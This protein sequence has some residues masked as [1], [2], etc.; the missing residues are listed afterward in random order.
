MAGSISPT[1]RAVARA[2]VSEVHVFVRQGRVSAAVAPCSYGRRHTRSTL[3]QPQP[4]G[5][6]WMW[7]NHGRRADRA[8]TSP[9]TFIYLF[10]AGGLKSFCGANLHN[11]ELCDRAPWYGY[12][13]LANTMAAQSDSLLKY[14]TR[15]LIEPHWVWP[16]RH[17]TLYWITR[18]LNPNQIISIS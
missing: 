15:L 1:C 2:S 6:S 7:H 4:N 3:A 9:N 13:E 18:Q 10:S 17:I 5:S 11:G 12:D 14:D 16:L 8:L